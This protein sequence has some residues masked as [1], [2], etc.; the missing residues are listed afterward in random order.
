MYDLDDINKGS[1]TFYHINKL[2]KEQGH[3][4][5]Q[6]DIQ[7]HDF[8]FLTKIFRYLSKRILKKK[9]FS[10]MD[11]F[12]A[13]HLCKKIE[14]NLSNETYDFILTNDYSVVSYLKLNKPIVLW[15]D[16]IFPFDYKHNVHPW[17][18]DLSWFSVKFSQ[19]VVRKALNNLTFCIVPGEWNKK[20]ILKYKT[21]DDEKLSIIPFGANISD[22]KIKSLSKKNILRKKINFLFVGKDQNAKGLKIAISVVEKLKLKN[23]DVL[24]NVVGKSSTLSNEK[25]DLIRYHGF[26]DKSNNSDLELLHSL[27]ECSDIYLMP[28]VA[29]GF[30]IVYME[31]AAYGIPSLGYKTTGVTGSVK[32]NYSGK[33]LPIGAS[34]SEFVEEILKWRSN[35]ALFNKLCK[36]SRKH[37]ELNGNWEIIIS[38]FTDFMIKEL[39]LDN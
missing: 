3:D 20:E 24:L 32:N 19:F 16:S 6:I 5:H 15:T 25:N 2:L 31:A 22:P 27:Y 37:Y 28:S 38:K 23:I 14:R 29:E 13:Y 33:L 12:I 30:G 39:N 1:G 11:P 21:I 17:L 36:N 10:Y 35:S 26:L 7:T 4:V 9:Y 8:P 34:S 18:N